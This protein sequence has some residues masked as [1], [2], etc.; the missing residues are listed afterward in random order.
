MP[1]V[2]LPNRISSEMMLPP[3]TTS[4]LN[5]ISTGNINNPA[6]TINRILNSV[7]LRLARMFKFSFKE[8]VFDYS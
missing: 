8:L 3:L 6:M 1:L 2:G 5:M 4:V 7:S